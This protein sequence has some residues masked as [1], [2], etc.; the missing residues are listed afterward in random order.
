MKKFL[1]LCVMVA[2]GVLAWKVGEKLSADSIGMAIGI[3]FGIMAGI[4][5]AL[6]MMAS[7]RRRAEQADAMRAME[8]EDRRLGHQNGGGGQPMIIIA[9]GAP[10]Q[11][12]QQPGWGHPQQGWDQPKMFPPPPRQQ[13][14][15]DTDEVV[16][17]GKGRQ[18][19]V[20]GEEGEQW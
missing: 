2:I 10:Q 8:K 3:L 17:T 14:I 18:F 20:V 15:V 4:P 11:L 12:P 9:G 13:P 5:T 19:R 7:D 6:M 16:V 1:A